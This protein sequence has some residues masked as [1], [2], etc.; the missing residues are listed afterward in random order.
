RWLVWNAEPLSHYEGGPAILAVGQDIT[1]LKQAQEHAL[2]SARLAS[3]GQM[4]T[5]LA[6]ESR[7][8]LQLI[9]ASL[10]MLALEVEDRPEALELIAS[11][12]AA[13][14]RLHRLFEDIRG[15]AAPIQLERDTYDLAQVW[16]NVWEHLTPQRNGRQVVLREHTEGTD[17]SCAV[18]LF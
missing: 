2:Q 18:D 11:I 5:G 16:R 8:A 3:I 9:Q 10:E 15:Y 4:V 12:Q 7:N 6:H 17:L 1:S 14:D 13:E